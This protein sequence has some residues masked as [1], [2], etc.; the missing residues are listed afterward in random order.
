MGLGILAFMSMYLFLGP[1]AFSKISGL[2]A[3][4]TYSMFSNNIFYMAFI[5]P[6]LLA[7]SLSMINIKMVWNEQLPF[8]KHGDKTIISYF[9]AVA[10]TLAALLGFLLQMNVPL[11]TVVKVFV[12]TSTG[13]LFILLSFT[14]LQDLF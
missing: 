14:F 2:N 6:L 1:D 4:E 11:Q 13:K 10:G 8:P 7:K 3:L 9:G 12:L 5:F